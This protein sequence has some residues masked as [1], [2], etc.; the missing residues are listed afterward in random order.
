MTT[1]ILTSAVLLMKTSCEASENVQHN[2][3]NISWPLYTR[4]VYKLKT[5]NIDIIPLEPFII[6]QL[7]FKQSLRD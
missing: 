5:K 6:K 3:D 1:F 7:V 4:A 2:P